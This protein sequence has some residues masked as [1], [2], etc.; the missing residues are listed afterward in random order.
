M[1]RFEK[2]YRLGILFLSLFFAG[3]L[4]GQQGQFQGSVPAG[5]ASPGK[6]ALTL[7]D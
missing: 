4:A 3:I 7:H 2:K 6:I 5:A 1:T